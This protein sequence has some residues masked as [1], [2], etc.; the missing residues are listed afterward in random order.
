[1]L[2][3]EPKIPQ[4]RFPDRRALVESRFSAL[5]RAEN[6]SIDP[7]IAAR[8][9]YVSFSALQRA[10]NSSIQSAPYPGIHVAEFQCS[11]ASRKFLNQ[12]PQPE[13]PESQRSV[14]VLF[15]EPKIP[16]LEELPSEREAKQ[17]VSVLFSEPKIP[18]SCCRLRPAAHRSA[19]SVLFSEPKIPQCT[20]ARR[21]QKNRDR[22]SALQRAENSSIGNAST[23][24][25]SRCGFSALQRAENSSIQATA[26]VRD[27]RL[28]FQCSSASRKFL[29]DICCVSRENQRPVSVLFS[30]PKIPQYVV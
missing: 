3:S 24:S 29:N 26:A 4:I 16:Q 21:F 2:F 6:S 8:W 10:E 23:S 18:Q 15:S 30:E 27:D 7:I 14:S 12:R 25:A 5:Q 17:Q 20:Q 9:A 28:R 13:E 1:V 19:V 11:S 22:F